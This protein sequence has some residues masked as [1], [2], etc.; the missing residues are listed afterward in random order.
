LT[1]KFPKQGKIDTKELPPELAEIVSV[2]L[3]LPEHIKSAIM[4]LV[5]TA[6]D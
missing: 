1:P 5:K 2:W 3:E 6:N 4:A